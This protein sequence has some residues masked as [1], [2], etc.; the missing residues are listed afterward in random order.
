MI[1]IIIVI[2]N[3]KKISYLIKSWIN[4]PHYQLLPNELKYN[5]NTFSAFLSFELKIKCYLQ[6]RII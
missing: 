4:N 1:I 3:N 5:Y 6:H 2:N